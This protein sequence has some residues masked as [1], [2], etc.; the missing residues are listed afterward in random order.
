MRKKK[1]P[2]I[3]DSEPDILETL[4][5]GLATRSDLIIITKFLSTCCSQEYHKYHIY[6]SLHTFDV[7]YPCLSPSYGNPSSS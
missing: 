3:T 2:N 5:L 4:Q 7:P 1:V 6:C